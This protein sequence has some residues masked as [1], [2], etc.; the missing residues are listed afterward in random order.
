VHLAELPVLRRRQLVDGA[1]QALGLQ[2]VRDADSAARHLVLVGRAD[3]APGGADGALLARFVAGLVQ[4]AVPGK[5]HVGPARY[6]HARRV[7]QHAAARELVDL[8][9]Q[10]HRVHHHARPDHVGGTG[11]QHAGRHHVQDRFLALD[12]Q[13]VSRV[14]AAVEAHHHVGLCGDP[15]DHLALALV[16]PLSANGYQRRH[17]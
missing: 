13:C 9:Q 16:A 11:L 17:G 3:A 2:Q 5:D 4:G 10:H 14:V 6:A 1:T 8:A 12:P 15:V 7:L